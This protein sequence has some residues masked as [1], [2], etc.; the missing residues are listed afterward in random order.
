[1][2]SEINARLR[3]AGHV[4]MIMVEVIAGRMYTGPMYEKYNASLRRQSGAPRSD[5]RV[6]ARPPHARHDAAA[7]EIQRVERG[8]SSR[9]E[10]VKLQADG[11]AAAPAT[12]NGLAV[13]SDKTK[14]A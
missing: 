3:S 7:T 4:E 11:R 14:P 6:A 9:G 13:K 5:A 8:R 2:R 1:M 12:A 10:L